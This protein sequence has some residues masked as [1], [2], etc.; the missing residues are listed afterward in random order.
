MVESLKPCP[1]CGSIDLGIARGTEDREGFPTKLYCGDCGTHG[2]WF[3]TRDKGYWTSTMLCAEKSGW[4]T[5][6]KPERHMLGWPDNLK[7]RYRLVLEKVTEAT[8]G[9]DIK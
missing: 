4:N 9:Q 7:G 8:D 5:R 1:F 6:A 3:Y 2:P